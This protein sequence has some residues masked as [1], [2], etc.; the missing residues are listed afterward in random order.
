MLNLIGPTLRF[1]KLQKLLFI[2]WASITFTGQIEAQE[3][4]G[5]KVEKANMAPKTVGQTWAVIVGVSQYLHIN[6]L[7]FAGDDALAFYNFLTSPA[8]GSVPESNIQ[9]LLNEKATLG[10]VDRAMGNLLDFVKPNDRVFLYFSGHG[11]QESRTIAQRGFL[12]THDS[13]SSNYNST[14]FAVLYLQDYIATLSTK[15]H[16]QILLFLDACR[17]GKLAGNEIGGVQLMGQQLLKQVANEV[18]FMAC[19]ANELSLEGY[20]WG[21]GRGLFSY[22]LIRGMQGLADT[23]G[24]KTV[25]LREL[26]RYLEDRVTAEAAPNPQNPLL[27]AA[28]KS[29]PIVKVDAATLESVRKNVPPPLFAAVQG[30][31][32]TQ[33]ILEEAETDVKKLY[34]DFQEAVTNKQLL[35]VPNAAEGYFERLLAA[36]SIKDMHPFI[37]REFAAALL[38]ESSKAF[39]GLLENRNTPE[40]T[41]AYQK[42]I[43]YLEKTYLILGQSHFLYP[44]LRARVSYYKGLIAEPINADAALLNFRQALDADST[45]APAYNDAGRILYLKKSYK[46][47]QQVFEKGIQFAPNW[48]F[49]HVNYGMALAAQN[50]RAEA[51]A[52]YKK[53]IEL[54]SDDP[55]VYK[56]YGNLLSTQNKAEAAEEAYKK[57]IELKTSDAETYNNY[58]MLL[59]AKKRYNEA[60]NAYRKA[61]E[62]QPNYATA[63]SNYGIVMAVQNRPAEAE[64]AFQKSIQL[65]P[66]DAQAHFNYGILLVSQNR[67]AEAENEYKKCI[68]LNPNDA[69]VYNSYGV[70]LAAQN[71]FA[72]AENAYKKY[73]EL[74]PTNS[75]VYGNYGNLLARQGRQN[76]AEAAYRRSIELNT[77]DA[78]VHKNYAVLLKNL[79][80]LTEAE[81]EYKRAIQLN[82]I[83]SEVYKNYGMLL[84]AGNRPEEAEVMYKK[85][86]EFNPNDAYIYNSY[87]ILL[88]AQNRFADAE[89]AYKKS[90]EL[91]AINGLVYSNYGNLL[92]RQNRFEEAE[93]AYKKALGFTPND[94]N[95]HNNYGNLL[96]RQNRLAEAEAS[97]K[98]V[99]ELNPAYFRAYYYIATI[100]ARQKLPFEA[101][102]WLGKALERGYTNFDSISKNPDFDYLR[103]MPEFTALIGRF[104]N[105]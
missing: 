40:V 47:A 32:V 74:N 102:E 12:L 45:F 88:A 30:R 103:E 2:F 10:Q 21:G 35:D 57:A 26:E 54:K 1:M 3:E 27:I 72:E 38:E 69:F 6:S 91:N 28:D 5:Q 79:N 50:K 92:S 31:G 20:Q 60:E 95:F 73:F 56:N 36:P 71:R 51:E 37:K 8:G 81:I 44:N 100:K 64:T 22:H 80:R 62:L 89:A 39:T 34:T 19:Q 29:L 93:T 99:I 97:Y 53:A 18:K 42:N 55:V 23:D 96:E 104:R 61:L 86:I 9:L 46:E 75:V 25:T 48:S 52:A 16:A 24:D 43:R 65:D 41:S 7:R 14:A 70:L 67:Q 83:D 11:D 77:N 63:Y 82:T 17:A 98:K 59:N 33:T 68:E 49:L 90:I 105:K 15:N 58:G 13:Y 76:E 94:A 85:A 87:G 4:R 84:S 101:V 78:N 66:N